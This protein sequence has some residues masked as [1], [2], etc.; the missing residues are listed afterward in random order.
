MAR[1]SSWPDRSGRRLIT[2]RNRRPPRWRVKALRS[3]TIDEV[4]R[5]LEVHRN[6]VRH[7]I[8]A[9]L[10]VIDDKRPNCQ[11]SRAAFLYFFRMNENRRREHV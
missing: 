5:T 9:G 1:A 7:W 10:P 6:T 2:R 11:R 4:A 3:Y 8:K